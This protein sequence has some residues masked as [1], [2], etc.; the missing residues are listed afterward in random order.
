[1]VN[2]DTGDDVVIFDHAPCI[3]IGKFRLQKRVEVCRIEINFPLE[4]TW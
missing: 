4:Y 1:M 3:I 2:P